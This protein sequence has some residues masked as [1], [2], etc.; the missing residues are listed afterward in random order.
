MFSN[1]IFIIYINK[2]CDVILIMHWML[3]NFSL[4]Y[5]F[6]IVKKYIVL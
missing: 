1:C 3:F 6:G 2:Y 5:Y 4:K